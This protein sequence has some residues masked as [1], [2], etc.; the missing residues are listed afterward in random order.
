MFRFIVIDICDSI[1]TIY[2]YIYTFFRFHESFVKNTSFSVRFTFNRTP[3]RLM[4]RAVEKASSFLSQL[5]SKED[6]P[7]FAFTNIKCLQ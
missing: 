7:N 2:I 4:H 3:L 1:L 5:S 6:L